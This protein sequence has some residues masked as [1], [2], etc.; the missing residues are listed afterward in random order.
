MIRADTVFINTPSAKQ[1]K[2]FAKVPSTLKWY[3]EAELWISLPLEQFF[4]N[5]DADA[6]NTMWNSQNL[7]DVIN[8]SRM[9]HRGPIKMSKSDGA[10]INDSAL[11]RLFCYCFHFSDLHC[12]HL[13]AYC[14]PD[15]RMKGWMLTTI[16]TTLPICFLAHITILNFTDLYLFYHVT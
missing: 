16:S 12:C 7:M 6:R 13:A 10:G 1:T 11:K 2:V 15:I 8:T 3:L 5:F 4:G 9:K 14:Y